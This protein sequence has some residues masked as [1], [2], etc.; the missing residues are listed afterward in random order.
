MLSNK[1][2]WFGALLAAFQSSTVTDGFAAAAAASSGWSPLD[3]P[4]KG[5]PFGSPSLNRLFPS[6]RGVSGRLESLEAT[7]ASEDAASPSDDEDGVTAVVLPVSVER[8]IRVSRLS[9]DGETS[10]SDKLLESD[11]VELFVSCVRLLL[12][13][14]CAGTV[15]TMLGV[16]LLAVCRRRL[17]SCCGSTAFGFVGQ[18]FLFQ[19]LK[20]FS[21]AFLSHLLTTLHEVDGD[22]G[23]EVGDKH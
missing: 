12:S 1:R 20:L 6:W 14:L 19:E 9:E 17:C 2:H 15:P 3:G 8:P 7:A 22:D 4:A 23:Q 21:L 5:T 18:K 10:T 16:L 13:Q 11:I